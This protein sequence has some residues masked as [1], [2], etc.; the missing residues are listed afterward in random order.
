MDT[1]DKVSALL[2]TGLNVLH[3]FTYGIFSPSPILTHVK[4]V[5]VNI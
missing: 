3:V 4:L 5:T 2:L 1:K